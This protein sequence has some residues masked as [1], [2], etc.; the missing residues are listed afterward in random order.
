VQAIVIPIADRH[1]EYAAKVLATLKATG[2]RAEMDVRGERMNAK[3]RDAQLQK[4]PYMLVVGDKEAA[5]D[6]VSV[7]LRSNVDLKAIPVS[8]FVEQVSKIIST[9]T[10]QLWEEQ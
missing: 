3:I 2:I 9:K 8:R 7:R 5:S 10:H 4:I 1:Q 6:A